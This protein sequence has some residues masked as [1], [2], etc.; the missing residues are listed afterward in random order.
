[1]KLYGSRAPNFAPGSRFEYSNYGF[2]L[3]GAII[4]AV[5]GESYYDYVRE[6]VFGPA[7]MT[8]Y[9]LAARVRGRTE[10]FDRLHAFRLRRAIVAAQHRL[11]S[12]EGYRRRWRLLD[13]RRRRAIRRR[14]HELRVAQPRLHGA[15]DHR[16]GG[17]GSRD[18]LCIRIRGQSRRGWQRLGRPRRRRSGHE[19][20]P[21]DLSR[22]PVTWSRCW[23]TS[24]RRRHSG[25]PTTSTRGFRLGDSPATVTDS[26]RLRRC[27]ARQG[28][29]VVR[30]RARG[31]RGGGSASHI[32]RGRRS[33]PAAR[34]D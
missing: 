28:P 9:G 19:R 15:A 8:V 16:Q 13:G 3:L 14:A 30:P 34:Q 1:M 10:P 22:S 33:R 32:R 6:H 2:V 12:L 23:R 20:G 29:G 25:S 17:P 5:S 31:S 27:E 21:E 18:Q 11:A 24:I 7:G 26:A 4:E